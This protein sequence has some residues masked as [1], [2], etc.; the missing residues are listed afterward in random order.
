MLTTPEKGPHQKYFHA[1][2]LP[3]SVISDTT[4]KTK[5]ARK[6]DVVTLENKICI[7]YYMLNIGVL[8]I[9]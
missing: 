6:I 5:K 7:F 1:I 8:L 2:L 4:M 9:K 3:T